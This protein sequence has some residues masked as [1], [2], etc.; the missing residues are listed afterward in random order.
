MLSQW[1]KPEKGPIFSEEIY[2]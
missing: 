2:Q 1:G